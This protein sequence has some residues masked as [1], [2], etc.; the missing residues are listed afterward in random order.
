[1][2]NDM[3]FNIKNVYLVK[4][5]NMDSLLFVYEYEDSEKIVR[6]NCITDCITTSWFIVKEAWNG[7]EFLYTSW[8]DTLFKESNENFTREVCPYNFL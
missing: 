7:S 1:M 4:Y 2:Y 5:I 3:K 6:Y 8:I